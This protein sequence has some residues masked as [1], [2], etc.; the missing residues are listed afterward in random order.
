MPSTGADER[1]GS[2]CG[3]QEADEEV[4][5]QM[6]RTGPNGRTGAIAPEGGSLRKFMARADE[7]EVCLCFGSGFAEMRSVAR[8]TADEFQ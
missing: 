7:A 3:G 1:A 2:R 6:G 8:T 5:K 4:R